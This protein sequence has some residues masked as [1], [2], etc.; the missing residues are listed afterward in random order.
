MLFTEIFEKQD[1]LPSVGG[2][3][4]DSLLDPIRARM[5]QAQY[6]VLDE[7][8]V[9]MAANVAQQKPSSIIACLPFVK[10][11]AP[12]MWIE[13]ANQHLRQS[14]AAM[15]SPNIRGE[16]QISDVERTGFLLWEEDGQIIMDHVH[17]DR[18]QGGITAILASNVRLAFDADTSSRRHELVSSMS[19]LIDK[20][21]DTGEPE[22]KSDI[23]ITGKIA[24]RL[25]EVHKNDAEAIALKQLSWRFGMA[26]HPEQK[27]FRDAMLKIMPEDKL[28]L[29]EADQMEDAFR[30][31][32]N[33]ILPGLILL[34]CRNAVRTETVPAQDRLNKQR[35][36]K[37][38]P[39]IEAYQY[40]RMHLT[41]KKK[42]LY[43]RYG[44]STSSTTGGLVIGHF[45]VRESGIFW[46]NPHWRGEHD[47]VGSKK[48]YVMTP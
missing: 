17:R 40:V 22:E 21:S 10:L 35:A 19:H 25:K 12:V 26:P 18:L 31:F 46:W 2:I 37:G 28:K 45:K 11:P 9:A 43:E 8:A 44:I 36:K 3:H 32:V 27:A 48:I 20:L 23:G 6:F 47:A 24:K 33:L 15:G 29:M 5:S 16:R 30:M 42:R 1:K 14:M 38:K 4:P 34:N 7:Q 13:F 39:P 41:P